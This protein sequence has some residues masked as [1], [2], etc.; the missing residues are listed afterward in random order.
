LTLGARFALIA[1]D[2]GAAD[3]FRIRQQAAAQSPDPS[4]GRRAVQ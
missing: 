4:N 1:V 2:D 3:S